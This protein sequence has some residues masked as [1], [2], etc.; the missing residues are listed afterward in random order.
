M[1]MIDNVK[2]S[3]YLGMSEQEIKNKTVVELLILEKEAEA[4][5]RDTIYKENLE[6]VADFKKIFTPYNLYVNLFGEELTNKYV[7]R[8]KL[9]ELSE[10]MDVLGNPRDG[11]KEKYIYKGTVRK[12]I[13]VPPKKTKKTLENVSVFIVPSRF[14]NLKHE[15]IILGIFSEKYPWILQYKPGIYN[16]EKDN[17]LFFV[18]IPC[19]TKMCSMYLP[20]GGFVR[21]E[22]DEIIK[23]NSY[24]G[25]FRRTDNKEKITELMNSEH[26]KALL[27]LIEG[28][29][30]G[31][32]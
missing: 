29:K 11:D 20:I 24:D 1:L 32:K 14:Q 15:K 18:K 26:T 7:L 31:D 3:K 22:V 28:N 8:Y 9:N 4:I 2:I 12:N 19:G 30:G 17:S 27:K 23:I 25:P 13:V 10:E 5:Y 6:R 16:I 21:G